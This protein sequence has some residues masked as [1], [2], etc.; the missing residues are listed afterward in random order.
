MSTSMWMLIGDTILVAFLVS[1]EGFKR[2]LLLCWFE[3]YCFWV[4]FRAAGKEKK[5]LFLVLKTYYSN[6]YFD[7]KHLPC[8]LLCTQH[9]SDIWV[10]RWKFWFLVRFG[11]SEILLRNVIWYQ[12][13]NWEPKYWSHDQLAK[14]GFLNIFSFFN[15]ADFKMF[16]SEI[17]SPSPD[18]F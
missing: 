7:G 12:N 18:N 14:K 13:S 10:L 11:N 16:F 9:G 2:W 17:R 8:T 4:S 15:K 6:K 5:R 3:L 1:L